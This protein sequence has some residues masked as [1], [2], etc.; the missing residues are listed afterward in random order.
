MDLVLT[1][2]EWWQAPPLGT[3]LSAE[4]TVFLRSVKW[5]MEDEKKE[6]LRWEISGPGGVAVRGATDWTGRAALE[7]IGD[8][9]DAPHGLVLLKP[10][11]V[12]LQVDWLDRIYRITTAEGGDSLVI[13]YLTFFQARSAPHGEM[14]GRIFF[15]FGT[16]TS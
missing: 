6:D 11:Q 14:N 10:E 2:E 16:G 4:Q 8:G 7:L 13:G 9:R 5:L 15:G 1:V 12:V 3:P